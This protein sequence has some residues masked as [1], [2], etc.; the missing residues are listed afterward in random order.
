MNNL[1]S[2]CT[3]INAKIRASE[4]DLPV[5]KAKVCKNPNVS[6]KKAILNCRHQ[7]NKGL[8]LLQPYSTSST[9]SAQLFQIQKKTQS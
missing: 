4:K 2:Y 8:E 9:K 1:S 6:E 5:L 3:L 7:P